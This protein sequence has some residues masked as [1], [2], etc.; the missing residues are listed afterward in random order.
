MFNKA[1][2]LAFQHQFLHVLNILLF[3]SD[4]FG[5]EV[6][7][8][9]LLQLLRHVRLASLRLYQ[10]HLLSPFVVDAT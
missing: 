2:N 1:L 9:P 8:Q 3:E 10:V 5:H 4:N 6:S 7:L